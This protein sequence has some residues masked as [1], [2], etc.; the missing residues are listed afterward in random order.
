MNRLTD[1][2][3]DTQGPACRGG[4]MAPVRPQG[5]AGSQQDSNQ[6]QHPVTA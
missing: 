5:G 4:L 3:T 1:T 2:G 6:A